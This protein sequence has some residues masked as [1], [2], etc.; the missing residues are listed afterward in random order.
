[1]MPVIII[2]GLR[3]GMFTPTEAAVVAAVY[4]LFIGLFVY[5]DLKLADLPRLFI[6]AAMTTSVVMFLVASA[7][8]ASYMIT[9]ADLPGQVIELFG[10]VLDQ[11]KLLM[12][13]ILILLTLVG[14]AMDL[15]PTILILGPVLKPLAVE[16][17]IDPVYF[18]VMF[19]LI[20]AVGLLTPPVGTVLNVV[21][22]VARIRLEDTIRG[23]WPYIVGYTLLLVL[24]VLVPELI[25]I[26]AS[27]LH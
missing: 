25:T 3:F 9:L 6:S 8:F 21:S 23:T 5:R 27:V 13:G 17:G 22:G 24:F 14:T 20:G 7:M 10:P 18:G 15:T 2:G 26:P 12:F 1:M 19:V 4:A 11:P 16:A